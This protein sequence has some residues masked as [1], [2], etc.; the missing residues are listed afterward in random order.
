MS[1]LQGTNLLSVVEP[2]L[3]GLT[4]FVFMRRKAYERYPAFCAFLSCRLG[5][6]IVL[7]SI[8]RL[9]RLGLVDKYVAYATY[10]YIFWIGYLAGAAMAFL[11][12]QSVFNSVIEPF[13]GL[14]RFGMI[15]FRWATATSVLIAVVMS[16]F[17]AGLNQNLLVV[18]TSGAMRCMSI[19][20]LCLLVFILLSMQ[21]LH[22][23]LKSK[24][25]G[26]ALGLAMIA[27]AELGG[28]AFAFGHSTMASV[29]NYASQIVVTLAAAVWAVTFS[30]PA[31]ERQAIQL[32]QSSPLHR[33]NEVARALAEPAQQIA[34]GSSLQGTFFL[35]EVEKAVDKVMERNSM[36]AGS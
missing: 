36:N 16:I 23:S 9:V 14:K 5:V 31:V 26:I 21:T 33:W 19:L 32:A 8:L 1:Y 13:P 12:I 17:P 27:S 6:Y 10:Y 34:L 3:L 20:E 15:G 28:S 18:A 24:E 29:A 35:Q 25:F 2:V 22:L 7:S 30:R 11:V 4:W